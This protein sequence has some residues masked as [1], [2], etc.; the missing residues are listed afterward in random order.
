MLTTQRS[1]LLLLIPLFAGL[2]IACSS[3]ALAPSNGS[4]TPT[5]ELAPTLRVASV[6]MLHGFDSD[7]NASTL[8]DRL[9]LVAD[10]LE[11]ENVDIVG[12]Q[13][14]SISSYGGNVAEELARRLGFEFVYQRANPN[15]EDATDEEND[16]LASAI[17]FEEG[18]AVISRFP[19]RDSEGLQLPRVSSAD[20]RVALRGTVVTPWGDIDI[21]S[22]HLTNQDEPEAK[23]GQAQA[24][25][26]WIAERSSELPALLMG[27]FNA[28]EGSE[29]INLL[30]GGFVDVYRA[31]DPDGPGYTC[32]QDDVSVAEPD[33]NLKRID[34]MFMVPG[35]SFA[36]DVVD[37]RVFLN[38]PFELA[39]GGALW[40]TDH[41]GLIVELRLFP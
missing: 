32:C 38:A 29:T 35:T 4:G 17:D 34:Y 18:E 27:D 9:G 25:A 2:L 39:D 5:T 1:P 20:N 6:N 7:V 12:L 22:T 15:I 36:G 19:I 8:L 28:R 26:D 14:S 13:E 11:A 23:A 10:A 41:Y 33:A 30:S 24:I 37:A 3:D 31:V 21:Y 16:T 40:A